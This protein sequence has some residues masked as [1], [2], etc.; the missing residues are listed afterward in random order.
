MNLEVD[1]LPSYFKWLMFGIN[2]LLAMIIIIY[3]K[4]VTTKLN[5]RYAES[6]LNLSIVWKV[7]ILFDLNLY[8]YIYIFHF[9]RLQSMYSIA[10]VSNN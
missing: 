9:I 3:E 5:K 7:I 8:I 4:I 10:F 6:E 2:I 1:S